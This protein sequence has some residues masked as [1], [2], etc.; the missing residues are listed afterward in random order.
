MSILRR[1]ERELDE[2][3][4]RLF[5][6]ASGTD[7]GRG[8]L[9]IQRA[10]LDE[11]TGKVRAAG[12]G[13]RVFPFR[14]LEIHIAVPGPGERALFEL[15]FAEGDQL[16]S[17]IRDALREA[18]CE[19]PA[20]LLAEVVLEELEIPGG[21]RIVY[22]EKPPAAA[23]ALPPA[24]RLAILVGQADQPVYA[25]GAQQVNVGRLGDVLD[26]EQRLVRRNQVAFAESGDAVNATVSRAHAHIE[27]HAENRE[28]RLYDDHSAYG[29]NIFRGGALLSVPAGAGR[30]V[31]LRPGDEIYF[32]QAKAR[33]EIE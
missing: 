15:A 31:A 1:V 25:L 4:R 26:G 8:A 30:G 6:S 21:F 24:A 22:R 33:F 20:D 18:G 3:L 7:Q 28:Y 23:P 14:H 9:E 5:T 2:R 29:T 12:R 16:S 19:P 17:D 11:V 32:G 27:Y 10:I 13:R